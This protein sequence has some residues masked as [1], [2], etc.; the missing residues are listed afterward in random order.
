MWYIL[1]SKKKTLGS[2]QDLTPKGFNVLSD[3]R[4]GQI[5]NGYVTLQFDVPSNHQKSSLL[6]NEGFIVYTN[7]QDGYELFRITEVTDAHGDDMRQ[8]VFCETAATREL[9]GSRIR[10]KSF[11]SQSLA[12]V[13]EFLLLNTG[14]ELGET[15][16]N[17]LVSIEFTDY[18]T[19]L[20]AIRSTIAKFSAE[21]EFKIEFDGIKIVRKVVNLY[22]KRGR[23]TKINFDYEHGLKG[24]T[25][26]SDSNKIF[27]AMI[28][29]GGEDANGRI[30]SIADAKVQF[31]YPFEITD[32]YVA[33]LDALQE[34]GN[35]GQ[36]VTGVYV[37]TDA[38]NPVDL[39]N[40]T[41]E[42]LKKSN[43][44]AYTYE[45]DVAFMESVLGYEFMKVQEGDTI[46]I[47]DTTFDPPLYLES[48]VLK[49]NSSVSKKDEG[50]VEL[51]EYVLLDVQPIAALQSI[52]KK[53]QI[54]EKAWNDAVERA[55]EALETAEQA[56]Q[57]YTVEVQGV[58]QYKNGQGENTFKA[59]LFQNGQ[60]I[61]PDGTEGFMYVWSMYDPF[62]RRMTNL[63]KTGKTITVNISE[64][65]TRCNVV[66]VAYK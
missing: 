45:A 17:D 66:C 37:D 29:V 50:S 15:F 57:S 61:D 58:S 23:D 56:K 6:K 49:K 26:K 5:E 16:Y 4:S 27:T 25:R 53:I 38:Q 64:F 47:T 36:H 34:F 63:S 41:L 35:N 42:E 52:Q 19:A 28:G 43:K 10:P 33:D 51:G 3:T 21:I 24:I 13:V 39:A 18:P 55:K 11:I 46:R 32:D 9:T 31:E 30:I 14:W 2:M 62:N 12:T 65:D 20:E 7:G 54:K 8:T 22:K 59:I 60:E 48:R 1:D 40:G 44:I